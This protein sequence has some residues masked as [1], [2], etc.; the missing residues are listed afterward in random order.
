M[1]LGAE[2]EAAIDVLTRFAQQTQDRPAPEAMARLDGALA[3][4]EALLTHTRRIRTE[5]EVR[6]AG[7]PFISPWI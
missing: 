5:L 7:R 1:S 6:M 4:L 3:D 2:V